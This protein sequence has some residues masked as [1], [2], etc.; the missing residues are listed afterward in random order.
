MRSMKQR[1]VEVVIELE[2]GRGP[3]R[4]DADLFTV[5][6]DHD[7]VVE[8]MDRSVGTPGSGIEP[9]WKMGWYLQDRTT[10]QPIK[11]WIVEGSEP[12]DFFK[13]CWRKHRRIEGAIRGADYAAH[14]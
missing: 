12:P 13:E 10:G 4:L 11:G 7:A 6:D 2:D 3:K 1:R 9:N 8:P 14:N 5:F